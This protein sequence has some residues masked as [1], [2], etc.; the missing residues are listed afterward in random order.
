MKKSRIIF[1]LIVLVIPFL[2]RTSKADAKS[3]K[4][5]EDNFPNDYFMVYI[6]SKFDTNDDG[7]LSEKERNAV[8]EIDVGEASEYQLG[9]EYPG[10][11]TVKG[12]EYFPNLEKL[13][14]SSG[15][16]QKLDVS[17]N[18]KLIRLDCSDN[19]LYKLNVE[20]N[21]KLKYLYCSGNRLKVLNVSAN[22]KL[23][24]LFC[25]G[26]ELTCI[27]V[28][29]N[30][31]LETLLVSNNKLMVLDLK[32]LKKLI[33][34]CC[35]GNRLKHLDVTHNRKLV[36]LECNENKLTSLDVSRNKKL[37]Y[38]HCGDNKISKL[39]LS[40]NKMIETFRCDNNCLITGN[41]KLTYTQLERVEATTQKATIRCKKIGKYY[42]IPLS[43]VLKTNEIT[44]LSYGKITEKGIRV[45]KKNL[46]KKITYE[47]N[48]FTDGDYMTKVTIKVKK[49]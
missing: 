41:V 30:R 29:G 25:S 28:S 46:P 27:D 4:I 13:D 24:E 3:V 21:K 2:F 44:N 37:D 23:E 36:T 19:S 11:D 6:R 18:T 31:Q 14:C 47:Y 20:H 10:P 17:Q 34:I 38:L 40:N 12:I 42:Y 15:C 32:K 22:K 43:G 8:T 5:D 39:N 48:M 7:K 45:K 1:V 33:E 16:I 26:N 35:G 9:L 49:K